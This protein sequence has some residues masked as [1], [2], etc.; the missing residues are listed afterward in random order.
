MR[1]GTGPRNVD[2]WLNPL[3]PEDPCGFKLIASINFIN[4]GGFNPD[5][6]LKAV[7]VVEILHIFPDP[8]GAICD[9]F[10]A[11]IL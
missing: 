11:E 2:D 4:Q 5:P 10:T 6:L 3:N 7:N 1:N 8:K 9:N